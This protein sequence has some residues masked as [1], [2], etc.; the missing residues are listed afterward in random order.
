MAIHFYVIIIITKVLSSN[1]LC[2]SEALLYHISLDPVAN[3]TCTVNGSATLTPCYSLQQLC[4]DKT[5]LS[6]KTQLT[7]LL[8]PGTH[9][10]PQGQTLSAS[11]VGKLEISPCNGH[12]VIVQCEK[13][14]NLTYRDVGALKVSSIEF[15][16]CNV[17]CNYSKGGIGVVITIE[18][19]NCF[20]ARNMENTALVVGNQNRS[21]MFNISVENCTFSSTYRGGIFCASPPLYPYT[22]NLSIT[23]T[24]FLGNNWPDGYGDALSVSFVNLKLQ[25]CQFINNTAKSVGAIFYTH[26]NLHVDDTVFESNR[27]NFSKGGAIYSLKSPKPNSRLILVISNTTFLEN[28]AKGSGGATSLYNCNVDIQNSKFHRNTAEYGGAISLASSH[29]EVNNSDFI[30]NFSR[31]FG[32]AVA[33]NN[34]EVVINHSNFIKNVAHCHGGAIF[35]GNRL[36]LIISYDTFQ[37]NFANMSGGAICLSDDFELTSCYFQENTARIALYLDPRSHGFSYEGYYDFQTQHS[38]TFWWCNILWQVFEYTYYD[39]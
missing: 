14:A 1:S 38:R 26:S 36:K 13:K 21:L 17:Q 35:V 3:E 25:G 4:E 18:I 9:V 24:L 16:S 19:L 10:I 8:L 34:G 28:V 33:C 27:A 20:F 29:L 5:L 2:S 15:A 30:E 37:G 32:G 23:N 22:I 31:R 11:G 12:L 6:N 7:L 39:I